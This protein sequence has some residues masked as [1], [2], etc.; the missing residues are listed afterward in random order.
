MRLQEAGDELRHILF[1][2]RTP[3][4]VLA[5]VLFCA[6]AIFSF[7]PTGEQQ[8]SYLAQSFLRGSLHFLESP[9]TWADATPFD[10][11]YYWPLGPFPAVVLVPFVAI[12]D[13]FGIF[14]YQGYLLFALT[15]GI[16]LLW[17]A[18][19]RVVSFRQRD[20]FL[21]AL[22]F[23]F[24]SGYILLAMIP[25]SWYFAQAVAVF[26]VSWAVY[27]YLT[28]RRSWVLGILMAAV[29]MT[30]IT[31]GVGALFFVLDILFLSKKTWKEK[32][33]DAVKFCTP[34]L[35]AGILLG[36]Y[37]FARFGDFFDQGYAL[38]Y[39]VSEQL[40][41][42]RGA[43]LFSFVHI[44]TN[45]YYLFLSAPLPVMRDI[46]TPILTLPFL[47]PDVWG[48]GIFFTSPY[49]LSLFFVRYRERV[50]A[51]LL[52]TIGSIVALLL[53]YWGTG[54]S[55]YG[56]RYAFEFFPFLFLLFLIV[57][58]ARG[59]LLSGG[60]RVLLLSSIAFNFYLFMVFFVYR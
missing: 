33:H 31:A 44:P 56:Y 7:T 36:L 25:W 40:R 9:G 58:K 48:M 42:V 4:A 28:K 10:G 53:V 24:G 50:H 34:L 11:K 57:Y 22:T 38:Q 16:F 46:M 41:N 26:L 29:S 8:F 6:A 47:R 13:G 21:L 30:R 14:F 2:S 20:A 54:Y 59:A 60:M 18:I 27:E 1:L 23:V 15:A 12:A 39:M 45:A 35:C 19:A 5:V 3:T 52:G 37:N 55:Q 17:Y 51:V 49:L 43:G 32:R